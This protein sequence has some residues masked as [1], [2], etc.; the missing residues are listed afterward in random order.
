MG[1]KATASRSLDLARRSKRDVVAPWAI[2][3]EDAF[4]RMLSLEQKR[5]QRSRQSFL[6]MLLKLETRLPVETKGRVLG[7]IL[8][9]L[10]KSTRETD[11]AGWY[12]EKAVAGVLFMEINLDRESLIP[13]T[14]LMR[15][16][17][18]LRNHLSPQQFEELGITLQLLPE[19]AGA[20]IP[21][22]AVHGI[23][24]PENPL[25]VA[26]AQSTGV[27]QWDASHRTTD[28]IKEP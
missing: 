4:Q 1:L 5:G 28:C 7:E 14:M 25:R 16:R 18:I 19:P 27:H 8:S 23:V 26:A 10:A 22:P 13:R 3:A 21:P 17:N 9:V 15:V 11:V 2:L 6:L 12:Q 24:I 20:E